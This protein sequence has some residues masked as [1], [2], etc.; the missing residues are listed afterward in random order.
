MYPTYQKQ[1]DLTFHEL[2]QE[3][4]GLFAGKRHQ[5]AM[6]ILEGQDISAEN[7]FKY[8][9][10]NFGHREPDILV[11]K[12]ANFQPGGTVN[13]VEGVVALVLAGVYLGFFPRHVAKPSND[14]VE[15]LPDVFSYA[16]PTSIVHQRNR[17]QTPIFRE[18]LRVLTSVSQDYRETSSD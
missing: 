5:L 3:H 14:Y 6:D 18:F 13:S 7:V 9:I 8:R 10:V 2:Y 12:K 17:Q 4:I 1:A 11:R 16:M 15:I